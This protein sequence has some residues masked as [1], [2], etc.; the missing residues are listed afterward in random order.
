[1]NIAISFNE[2]C[3]FLSM[4]TFQYESERDL[5]NNFEPNVFLEEKVDVKEF[6][7]VQ[8]FHDAVVEVLAEI[9]QARS[10]PLISHVSLPHIVQKNSTLASC[11]G[12]RR[13]LLFDTLGETISKCCGTEGNIHT[14]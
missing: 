14:P 10:T 5:M 11:R 8:R 1:M 9:R 2:V 6:I 4:P 13:L 7:Q 12:V 3:K